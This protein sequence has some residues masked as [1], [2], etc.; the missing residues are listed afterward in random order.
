MLNIN[1][2]YTNIN[3]LGRN[4]DI[5]EAEK[6]LHKIKCDFPAASSYI[7]DLLSQK[8][9]I[10]TKKTNSALKNFTDIMESYYN[11]NNIGAKKIN[12]KLS[13]FRKIQSNYL[14]NNY[15][16]CDFLIWGIKNFRV[17]NCKENSELA[18]L[19]AKINGY[20]DCYCVNLVKKNK[21]TLFF[22]LLYKSL[23]INKELPKNIKKVKKFYIQNIDKN[24]TFIPS[25]KSIVIDPLF[26]IVDYWENAIQNYKTIFPQVKNKNICAVA[27]ESIIKHHYNLKK[28]QRMYPELVINSSTQNKKVN[29]LNKVIKILQNMCIISGKKLKK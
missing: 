16:Y 17:M 11:T 14:N 12:K 21:N 23:L 13:I 15:K 9:D 10:E 26:G 5:K 4:R 20:R 22:N 3:F 7:A 27:I 25:R 28:L 2:K 6:I 29:F 18:F 8:Y 1:S 19:I 24:Y